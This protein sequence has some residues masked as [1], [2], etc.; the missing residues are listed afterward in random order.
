MK[1]FLILIILTSKVWANSISLS[2]NPKS[3]VKEQSFY[4][5]FEIETNSNGTP[6]L[7][8]DPGKAEVLGRQSNGVEISTTLV[9][10]RLTTR[11]VLKYRY[12][13]VAPTSG[14]YFIKE[15]EANID[16]L[17]LKHEPIRFQV[18]A[19]PIKKPAFFVQAEPKKRSYY[20]REVIYLNYYYYSKVG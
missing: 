9:N 12:E 15:I 3:P 19:A 10:G 7:S 16:G 5:D 17:V 18:V 6:V 4:L 2:V 13:L 20:L 11:R 1:I 8:F 14:F